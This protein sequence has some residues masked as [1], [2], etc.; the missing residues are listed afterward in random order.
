YI[1]RAKKLVKEKGCRACHKVNGRGNNIA[2]DLTYEG[3]KSAESFDYSRIGGFPSAFAWHQRHF[4]NP[5]ELVEDSIMPAFPMNSKDIQ[6][7]SMLV[8]SWKK[9]DIPVAYLPG[10]ETGDK[11]TPEELEQERKMLEGP[12]AIFV[13]KQCFVC[14]SISSMDVISP[15]N[16]GPDLSNAVADVRSRF[17]REL[18]EFLLNPT[19]TMSVVLEKQII[20]TREEKLQ[21][22][23][24]L[25]EAYQKYLEQKEKEDKMD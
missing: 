24:K 12:G 18:E 20:L 16:I 14:H 15:A 3:D 5:K 13:E 1:N 11:P 9:T 2:P 10:V 6:A 4:K 19:G 25:K 23:E 7:L 21:L 8:M 17:G 22:V